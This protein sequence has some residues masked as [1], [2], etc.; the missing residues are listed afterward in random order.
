MGRKKRRRFSPQQKAQAVELARTSGKSIA[1]LAR[2]LDLT[3]SA[4]ANWVKQ[5]GIDM[6][7]DPT[8]ALTTEERTELVQLRR[9]KKRLEQENAFLKKASAFFAKE[10]L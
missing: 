10:S 4:L 9:D 6:K 8:G 1:E 3:P 5:A 7:K 2:D